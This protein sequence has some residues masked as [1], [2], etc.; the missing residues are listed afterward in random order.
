MRLIAKGVLVLFLLLFVSISLSAQYVVLGIVADSLTKEHLSY[1]S[2]YLKGTTEGT[3]YGNDEGF[4]TKF[5]FPE[6]ICVMSFICYGEY[7]RRIHPS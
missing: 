6:T 4:Y 3:I 1:T 5:R 2:V 7:R